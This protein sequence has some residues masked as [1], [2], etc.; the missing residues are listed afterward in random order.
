MLKL[1]TAVAVAMSS[2]TLVA[3]PGA[4]PGTADPPPAHTLTVSGTGIG[5]YPAYD[6]AISRYAATTTEATFPSDTGQGGDNTTNTGG[7]VTVAA[8]TSDPG[9]LVLVDGSPATGQTTLTDVSGGD[10]ISVIYIDS[11]GREADSVV[12]LPADFPA[13]SATI[14]QPGITPGDVGLTLSQWQLGNGWPMFDTVVDRNGVPAWVRSSHGG[15][16]DLKR[17]PDGHYS[18]SRGPTASGQDLGSI[19]VVELNDQFQPMA[20]FHTVDP[21][22]QTDGHD[23]ILEADGSRVLIASQHNPSTGLTDAVIQEVDPQGQVTFQWNSS[24][25]AGETVVDPNDPRHPDLADYAHINSVQIVNGGDDFLA[26]FRHLSAVLEIAR[27]AHDGYQPGAIVW[28]LGGRDSS[29]SFVDDPYGGPCAQHAASQ[30]PDGD[31]M[32]FDDGSTSFFGKLCV[33]QADPSGPSQERRQSRMAIY[34]LD[35][36]AQT[37]TLVRSY[38]PTGWFAWFMGSAQYLPA[39]G[40]I[41][42]GWASATQ[43]LATELGPDDTPV[44]EL[45][46]APSSN[47]HTYFSYRSTKFDV[48]DATDPVVQVTTPADGASYALGE[49]V[50]TAFTCTDRGGSTLQTCGD[51]L[52]GS[53]LDTSVLGT[54]TFLVTATD[55]A[56]NLTRVSHD[57]TVTVSTAPPPTP[58][59]TAPTTPPSTPVYRPDAMIRAVGGTW[60]G[61]GRYGRPSTQTVTRVLRSGH[62]HARVALAF[63]NDGDHADRCLVQGPASSRRFHLN[64][65]SDGR[66]VTAAVEAGTWRTPRL[67]PGTRVRLQ[68]RVRATSYAESGDRRSLVVRC[69][70]VRLPSA[71]DAVTL[72]VRFH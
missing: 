22:T 13:M 17:Q 67:A 68:V 44:W 72:R 19:Q 37:A 62:D 43:A 20:S 57:Y 50:P 66:D 60:V 10:E 25:L 65:R 29:F 7:T 48:P 51:Q 64:Y 35:P 70:S 56:G 28:Q 24:A 11:S 42:I 14:Q 55:G 38:G 61:A 49:H 30:L 40:N 9:G 71:H 15:G 18:E 45:T 36:T 23:S 1:A 59:T 5:M 34:H 32:V 41:L 47:G 6:P 69:G 2:L 16:M 54:H 31:I 8:T 21:L 27:R 12:V 52:P 3:G 63:R 39:T 58:P 26:S 33:D 4:G 46:A 53:A